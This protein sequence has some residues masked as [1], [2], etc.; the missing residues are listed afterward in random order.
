MGGCPAPGPARTVRS[1]QFGCCGVGCRNGRKG[2]ALK[3][4]RPEVVTR[5]KGRRLIALFKSGLDFPHIRFVS[6]RSAAF[7]VVFSRSR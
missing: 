4:H 7:T 5:L 2:R 1:P 3:G 6:V